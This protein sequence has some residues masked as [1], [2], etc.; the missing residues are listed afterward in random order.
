MFAESF[1]LDAAEAVCG[2]GDLEVLD[3]AGLLGSLADKSLVVAEPAGGT[4]R[5]RLLETIRQFAAERLAEAGEDEAAALA[6]AHC[7]HFLSCC[8]GGGPAPDRAG[9]GPVARAAGRRAGE[10]AARCRARGR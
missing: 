3:V 7:A 1:D 2:F 10:P 9:P 8:R 4:L 6:A 5:Y